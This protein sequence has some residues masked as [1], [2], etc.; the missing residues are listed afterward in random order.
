MSSVLDILRQSDEEGETASPFEEIDESD[1]AGPDDEDDD[2]AAIELEAEEEDTGDIRALRKR[3]K[4]HVPLEELPTLL[5]RSRAR[6]QRAGVKKAQKA[7]PQ[8]VKPRPRLPPNYIPPNT[9][10][11]ELFN[12]W[13]ARDAKFVMR[14]D[15][16]YYSVVEIPC[17][18]QGTEK[19]AWLHIAK[20]EYTLFNVAVGES[21]TFLGNNA[22]VTTN[23]TNLQR[24]S[25]NTYSDQEFLIQSITMQEAGLRVRYDGAEIDKIGGLG[26][27]KG[28][29]TG[30]AWL[31]DDA[32]TFL[33]KEIFHDFS[34]EN[35]LY[36]TVRRSAV[37]YFNWDKART[38]GNATSRKVLIDHLRNV[39]D[40]KVRTLSRTS[41]GAAVL[42]VPDGYVFTDNP[43]R[44]EHG[45]FSALIHIPED[46]AFPIRPIDLGSGAPIR[47]IEVGLYVQLSLNGI[48]FEHQ[49]SSSV[50][51]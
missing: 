43:E 48:A 25:K 34:G 33:P 24:P 22:T 35:L 11:R 39:P 3:G 47:P 19:I 5:R 31:W 42:P 7:Q 6:G 49:K 21:M 12:K 15:G 9:G 28:V 46:I 8:K 32:G 41:G 23:W 26:E 38:G 14:Q 36:R 30:Q 17:K 16:H 20:G 18:C 50:T 37:V 2:T 44:S 40:T 10:A 51:A 4:K 13:T 45:A 29:L 27:A 1:T